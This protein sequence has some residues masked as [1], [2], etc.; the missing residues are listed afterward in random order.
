MYVVVLLTIGAEDVGPSFHGYVVVIFYI[1]W[2]DLYINMYMQLIYTTEIASS[3]LD[4]NN[5]VYL[6]P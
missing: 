6:Y 4:P 1:Y 2:E 3:G 5:L